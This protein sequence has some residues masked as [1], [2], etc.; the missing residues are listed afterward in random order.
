MK[1]LPS[2]GELAEQQGVRWCRGIQPNGQT[3]FEEHAK[4]S[5]TIHPE[6]RRQQLSTDIV[7]HWSDR[8]SSR[9]G[10]RRFLLL[11]ANA[12]ITSATPAIPDW[13]RLYRS[14]RMASDMAKAAH[15]RLPASLSAGD[16]AR[17]R[18]MLVRV[19]MA[20]PER[21]EAYEWTR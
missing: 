5:Y 4:G 20:D 10:I 8:R 12:V 15:L 11:V 13:R 9:A 1:S 19:S 16:R 14:N 6:L 18:A 2:Y 21:R 17:L 7:I 3:C